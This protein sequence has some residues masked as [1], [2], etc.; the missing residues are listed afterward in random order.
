M[1]SLPEANMPD[2]QQIHFCG[3]ARPWNGSC[4][5]PDEVEYVCSHPGPIFDLKTNE[6]I[7]VFWIND[8]G[9]INISLA[10]G[11]YYNRSD[12]CYQVDSYPDHHSEVYPYICSQRMKTNSWLG[13]TYFD[14]TDLGVNSS[15]YT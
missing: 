3:L 9:K 2:D 6:E 15:A 4:Q 1:T 14:P 11:E 12:Y 5:N 8:I 7:N 13:C 10:H